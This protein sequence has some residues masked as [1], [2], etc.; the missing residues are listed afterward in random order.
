MRDPATDEALEILIEEFEVAAEAERKCWFPEYRGRELEFIRDVLGLRTRTGELGLWAAQRAIVEA[1]FA[2]KFVT[3]VSCRGPGKSFA[4]AAAVLAF[5]Y[6]A[7]SRVILTA[8]GLRLCREVLFGMLA[9]LHRQAPTRLPGELSTLALRL[10]EQHSVVGIPCRDP[11]AVRGFHSTP[12]VPS[13]P[14]ADEL[15]PEDLEAAVDG[16]DEGVRL[17]IVVDEAASVD[18]ATLRVLRGMFLKPNVHCLMLSNPTLG[19]DDEHPYLDALEDGSG[20][21]RIKVSAFSEAEFPDDLSNSYDQTFD[22]VPEYLISPAALERAR[23]QHE[24]DDPIF[25]SDWLGQFSKGSSSMQVVPRSALEAALACLGTKARPRLGPRIGVDIGAGRPDPCVAALYH[26]GV[27]RAAHEWRPASDDSAA[28]VSIAT[29]IAALMVKWGRELG[30]SNPKDWDGRP[31]DGGRVSVDDSG[32]TGVCDILASRGV[33]VDRVVFS[34]SPQGH[35]RELTGVA[36]FL[37][38][39]AEMYWTLRRGLQEG[40]FVIPQEFGKSWQQLQWTRFERK[41]DG[42]GPL[43][44]MEAKELV[45]RRHGHSPD[46]ADADALAC[47]ETSPGVG[48]ATF[49]DPP[50]HVRRLPPPGIARERALRLRGFKR[51]ASESPGSPRV[52]ADGWST[53]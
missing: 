24:P 33:H 31:I 10:D 28:Q 40:V 19:L 36:R 2:R 9:T 22:H 27:K 51:I 47:R 45:V 12:A 23:R 29:T 50:G 14:D 8:P 44:K 46:H 7:R 16:L 6:T 25:Q 39:R 20:W 26:N 41:F 32:L 5:F 38:L 21:W 11:A 17:L 53:R 35:W 48:A 34:A 18:P 49:G 42:Y 30:V 4:A 15:T 37:N 52:T 3:V 1:V 43:L 13:D